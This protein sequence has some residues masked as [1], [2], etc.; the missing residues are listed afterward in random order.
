MIKLI[1][2]VTRLNGRVYSPSDGAFSADKATEEHL[3][4]AGVAVYVDGK[5]PTSAPAKTSKNETAPTLDA[6]A[7][8]LD[9]ESP[10]K[11]AKK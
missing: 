8:S 10:K 5:T 7:P 4:K 2:G 6:E 1:T 11:K 9:A 3:V